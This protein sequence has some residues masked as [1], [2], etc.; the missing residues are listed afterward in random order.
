[1]HWGKYAIWNSYL[2]RAETLTKL[3]SGKPETLVGLSGVGDLMLTCF[4]S[5]S[6]NNRLGNMIA[7]GKTLEEA[8]EVIGEVVEGVPTAAE[9]VRLADQHKLR[10]PLFRAVAAILEGKLKPADGLKMINSKK[11]GREDFV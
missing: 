9:I 2:F 11:P 5:Q 3:R 6:R 7:N 8:F 4:S 10:M 1:M